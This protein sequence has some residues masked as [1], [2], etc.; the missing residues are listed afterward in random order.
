MKVLMGLT[1]FIT[2][3]QKPLTGEE[4]I[5]LKQQPTPTTSSVRYSSPALIDGSDFLNYF[6]AIKRNNPANDKI[7]LDFTCSNSKNQH[8]E[9]DILNWYRTTNFDFKKKLI[10]MAKVNDSVFILNYTANKFA[11]KT[12]VTCS[13]CLE[14]NNSFK[15]ILP[16]K[17]NEFLR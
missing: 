15:I 5:I 4:P 14:T 7:L 8:T 13:V 10:A 17:L 9:K 6:S 12:L 2:A 3:C 16:V 11:T 1:I